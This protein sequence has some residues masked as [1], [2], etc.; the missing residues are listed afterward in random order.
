MNAIWTTI[1]AEIKSLSSDHT[2]EE[3]AIVMDKKYCVSERPNC[4]DLEKRQNEFKEAIRPFVGMYSRE[5]CNAFYAYW[6]EPN[7]TRK[8]MRFELE[9]TWDIKKRLARWVNTNKSF[10]P[11]V[12]IKAIRPTLKQIES[13]VP[14]VSMAVKTEA[15]YLWRE[16]MRN[17]FKLFKD[18]G[19]LSPHSPTMQY[20]MFVELGLMKDNFN[21]FVSV[22]SDNVVAIKKQMRIQ[23]TSRFHLDALNDSIER[24]STGKHSDNDRREVQ[25]QAKLLAIES[26]Y[27]S[28][29]H[30]DI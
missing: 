4:N 19:I 7:R 29:D 6:S 30:L 17:Q 14:I 5:M 27:N 22:A 13:E 24:I 12:E 8:K 11:K 23:P 26:F 10:A 16:S 15:E 9:K 21:D 25:Q 20:K 28:I 1:I 2:D 18:K 3:L